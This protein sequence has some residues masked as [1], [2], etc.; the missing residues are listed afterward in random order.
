MIVS[1]KGYT[2]QLRLELRVLIK[3]VQLPFKIVAKE[4]VV[5]VCIRTYIVEIVS[6]AAVSTHC[7]TYA[8]DHASEEQTECCSSGVEV[9]VAEKR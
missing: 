1:A 6:A 2:A 5:D 7:R 9:V 4:N 3:M 8:Y